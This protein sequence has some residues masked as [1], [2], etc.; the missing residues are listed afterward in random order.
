[1]RLLLLISF[2]VSVLGQGTHL[3]VTSIMQAQGPQIIYGNNVVVKFIPV[4]DIPTTVA[5]MKGPP[6]NLT[7]VHSLTDN[8]T[9]GSY[10]WTMPA[11]DQQPA[12]FYLKLSRGSDFV[13]SEAFRVFLTYGPPPGVSASRGGPPVGRPTPSSVEH[14]GSTTSNTPTSTPTPTPTP[15][16]GPATSEPLN[17]SPSPKA[18]NNSGLSTGAKA[19]VGV[20]ASLGALILLFGAFYI[21]RSVQRKRMTPK[22]DEAGDVDPDRKDHLELDGDT[23]LH[24]LK[25]GD[26][27]PLEMG[28]KVNMDPVEL[29]G[30]EYTSEL[31]GD[32]THENEPVPDRKSVV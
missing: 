8:A 28:E 24:E 10:T 14:S 7:Q 13:H 19:G 11:L 1:M 31:Q 4:D 5:I 22:D 3:N 15:T 29:P 32:N 18:E 26:V 2:T 17:P 20:G 25:E 9:Q 30:H 6:D 23:T 12:T 21:G 27:Y 16:G